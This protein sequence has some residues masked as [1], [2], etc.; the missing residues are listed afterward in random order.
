MAVTMVK[1]LN[2]KMSLELD[3]VPI[4]AVA[5]A[6][7]RFECPGRDGPHAYPRATTYPKMGF[8][9]QTSAD[10]LVLGLVIL[11]KP[12]YACKGY[13]AINSTQGYNSNVM[14]EC[15]TICIKSYELHQNM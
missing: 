11:Q 7:V 6:E 8:W 12:A 10:S 4:G 14:L 3:L 9:V 2:E 15:Q 1:K 13:V 5:E